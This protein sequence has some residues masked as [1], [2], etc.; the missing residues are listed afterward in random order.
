MAFHQVELLNIQSNSY[1][2]ILKKNHKYNLED[3]LV[4]ISINS[5]KCAK[6]QPRNR[7]VSASCNSRTHCLGHVLPI[8]SSTRHTYEELYRLLC[9]Q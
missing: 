4:V 7:D 5:L 9:H 2:K 3:A 8:T 6:K 1:D